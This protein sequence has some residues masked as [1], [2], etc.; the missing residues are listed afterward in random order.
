MT[1]CEFSRD[2]AEL[3]IDSYKNNNLSDLD[4]PYEKEPDQ[5]DL[6]Q[7]G[8][9][10]ELGHQ[11]IE[12]AVLANFGYKSHEN[13]EHLKICEKNLENIGKGYN[14]ADNT[15]CLFTLKQLPD[16]KAV[17]HVFRYDF[18]AVFKSVI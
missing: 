4:F 2:S 1:G 7:R 14:V 3:V 13:Y 9:L 11:V 12:I 10:V 5:L 8:K 16:L 15:S 18:D 17:H 6:P